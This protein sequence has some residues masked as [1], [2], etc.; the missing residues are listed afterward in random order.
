VAELSIIIPTHNRADKLQACLLA[1]ARQTLP[2]ADFDVI[3]VVDGSTDGTRQMLAELSVPFELKVFWQ[4]NSGQ[5]AALN[6]GL[7]EAAAPYCLILDDDVTATS[8]LAAEHLRA[9]R[10]NKGVVGIGRLN[11]MLP[12]QADRFARNLTQIW[13]NHYDHLSQ[14]RPPSWSDAFS[15][16]L[17]AP[18]EGLIRAGGF[19][20]DLPASFDIELSYRLALQ[21]LSFIYLPNAVGIHDD[22]KGFKQIAADMEKHGRAAVEVYRRHPAMLPALLGSFGE[23]TVR[24]LWLDR[25]L[26]A[27]N[28]SWHFLAWM[29]QFADNRPWERAWY[30]FLHNY[31]YWRGV[32]QAISDRDTWRRLTSGTAILMYHAFAGAREPASRYIVPQRS[33]ALQMA[34]LKLLRYHVLS[35]SDYI[36]YRRAY[37]LPPA[38]SVV[39]SIDDGYGDVRTQALSVLRRHGFPAIIFIVTADVGGANHW[40]QTG[41]LAGRLLLA[42]SDIQ[43]L[44]G[45]GMLFGAHSRTH[46]RLT[47]V[48]PERTED[49]IVGSRADLERELGMPVQFLAYPFGAYDGGTRDLARQAG[50]LGA[51][52]THRGLNTPNTP[53]FELRRTEVFGTDSILRFALALWLGDDHLP[54]R[55]G[56]A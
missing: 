34:W 23:T 5:C 47:D 24:A 14:G 13:T 30:S 1:L 25:L 11:L 35:L 50:F 55:R 28:V 18:R 37:Q 12:V 6:R 31:F 44:L 36:S 40:D 19:A 16:N 56:N 4:E 29:S 32:H 38:R 33:F 43:K 7:A 53:W 46:V 2:A 51:C 26:L 10:E 54:P 8:G 15:G 39:I 20:I 22:Y 42:W 9:Q 52:S 3:V 41:P 49:E 17:S 27:F 48:S 21:G 45:G